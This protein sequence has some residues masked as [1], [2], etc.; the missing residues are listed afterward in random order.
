[1]S[2]LVWWPFTPLTHL[3]A[4][5][6]RYTSLNCCRLQTAKQNKNINHLYNHLYTIIS[7]ELSLSD[8]V[9]LSSEVLE[10]REVAVLRLSHVLCTLC[11][12][13]EETRTKLGLHSLTSSE[14]STS[15]PEWSPRCLVELA[16]VPWGYQS[17]ACTP[18]RYLPERYI[19]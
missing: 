16:T 18:Q 10:L 17:G 4:F 13:K 8:K 2:F 1:M 19:A 14:H 15:S 3:S 9:S 12:Y 5:V 11:T 6:T 7:I